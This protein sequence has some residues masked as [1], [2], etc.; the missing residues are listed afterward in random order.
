MKIET[1]NSFESFLFRIIS[2]N[3]IEITEVHIFST[4]NISLWI[5]V[6]EIKESAISNKNYPILQIKRLTIII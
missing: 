6:I 3:S 4:G 1:H 2:V 5:I